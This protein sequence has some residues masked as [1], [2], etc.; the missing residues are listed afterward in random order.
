MTPYRP[1]R[2]CLIPQCPNLAVT[3][4]GYC[5]DH[6]AR[7]GLADRDRDRMRG[8]SADRGYDARWRK[9]R[10]WYLRHHPFCTLCHTPATDIHHIVSLAAGGRDNEENLQA[11]CHSCHSRLTAKELRP[12]LKQNQT[13]TREG[14]REK[15]LEPRGD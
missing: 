15:S 14:G 10:R 6:Q 13:K 7:I 4:T 11:L 3:G 9:R 8:H 5:A 12:Q 2:P 1:A